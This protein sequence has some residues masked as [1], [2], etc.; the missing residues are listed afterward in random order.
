MKSHRL[1]GRLYFSSPGADFTNVLHTAFVPTNP[2]IAKRLDCPF[3]I[4]GFSFAKA[5]CKHVGE[6][7]PCMCFLLIRNQSKVRKTMTV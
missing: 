6:I 3:T 7:D 1:K 2:K 5:V 4:L